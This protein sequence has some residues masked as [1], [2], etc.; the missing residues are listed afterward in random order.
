[1]WELGCH[2]VPD[3]LARLVG[4]MP[5]ARNVGLGEAWALSRPE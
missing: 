4:M 1:M 5:V 2:G 3:G